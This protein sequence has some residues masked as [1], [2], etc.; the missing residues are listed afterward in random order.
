MSALLVSSFL[1]HFWFLLF[2]LSWARNLQNSGP[3]HPHL[4]PKEKLE[5]KVEWRCTQP[6]TLRRW[7]VDVHENAIWGKS[8]S[9]GSDL[10]FLCFGVTRAEGYLGHISEFE[11]A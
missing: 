11:L 7:P 2:F 4:A 3:A 10:S 1:S 9:G 8:R 6:V 5:E